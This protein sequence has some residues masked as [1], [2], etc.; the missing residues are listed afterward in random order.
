MKGRV[1]VTYARSWYTVS[2][3]R[4]LGRRGIEV[5]A[6]DEFG[7]TPGSLSRH[8]SAT[9]T[10]PSHADDP[11]GFMETMQRVVR[12]HRPD[13]PETSYVLMPMHREAY[14][15]AAARERF[16]PDIALPLPASAS[17][18]RVRHKARLAELARELDIAIPTTHHPAGDR[19]LDSLADDLGYPA[20]VKIPSG[21]AGVGVE[22]VDGAD[23]LR[24]V[25]RRLVADH[26]LSGID[27]PIVQELA[28]GDDY[29]ATMILDR[30]TVSAALAY[31]NALTFPADSG[32]G[33]VR[34]TVAAP[35]MQK[36]AER[37]LG[38]L[39]WHG[40]AQVDFRWT[41]D[42]EDEPLLIEVNPRFFGGLSHAIASG[43][44]YPWYLY[45][46]AA[47]GQIADLDAPEIGMRTEA[48]VVG[49]LATLREMVG[50]G[51]AFDAIKGA[52]ADARDALETDKSLVGALRE[53]ARG[54]GDTMT[55]DERVERARRILEENADNV[56][57]LLDSDDPMPA[58]GLAYPLAAFLERG[59]LDADI[60]TGVAR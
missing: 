26:A 4:S 2:A 25:Y 20:F 35:R 51:D 31:R 21:A 59:S 44:D 12:E 10:Y 47:W 32:P 49:M 29:C 34:E 8:T 54:V 39:D 1:I 37:L 6:G 45:Q 15:L 5:I 38:E 23:E 60:L 22:R 42:P 48:P 58:L 43:V 7:L 27:R 50:A 36:V 17:I 46:L 13:D 14:A 57:A 3:I 16:E 19:E 33:A 30:G 28:P 9:F 11:D 24:A 40:I 56:S 53:L 55:L 52:W 41:G 18:E